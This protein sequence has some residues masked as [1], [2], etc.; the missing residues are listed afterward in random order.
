MSRNTNTHRNLSLEDGRCFVLLWRLL[1]RYHVQITAGIVVLILLN[2]LLQ[3]RWNWAGDF[4][5]F[6]VLFA[7]LTVVLPT[8]AVTLMKWAQQLALPVSNITQQSGA[9]ASLWVAGQLRSLVGREGIVLCGMLLLIVGEVST[10]IFW[11]PW[12]GW[13]GTLFF[14]WAAIFFFGYGALGWCFGCLSVLLW[15]ISNLPIQCSPFR[16]PTDHIATIYQ[17]YFRILIIGASLYALAVLSVWLSPGGPAIALETNLGM[18]WVFLPAACIILFFLIFHF[19]VHRLLVRC[20]EISDNELTTLLE[21]EYNNW[22]HDPTAEREN[23]IKRVLE[24][25]DHIRR[26]DEWPLSLQSVVL[27]ITT[28]LL[29]TLK[30]VLE[31]ISR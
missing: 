19:R 24:W 17:T 21:S 20:K 15:R 1:R 27:T 11:V 28:L 5:A 25:R 10:V 26:A 6:E 9:A 30:E 7:L 29:P 16:W 2:L 23:R 13:I 22:R 12:E 18:L 31:L 4:I 3:F 14:L 8:I